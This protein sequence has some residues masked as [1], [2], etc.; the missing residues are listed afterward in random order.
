MSHSVRP[1]LV[2]GTHLHIVL[3][4]YLVL[5]RRHHVLTVASAGRQSIMLPGKLVL[6]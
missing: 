2:E 6:P 5:W 4:L 3:Q 1:L